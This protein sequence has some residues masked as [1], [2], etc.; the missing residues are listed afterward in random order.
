MSTIPSGR[1]QEIEIVA[2]RLRCKTMFTHPQPKPSATSQSS[3]SGNGT[4]SNGRSG[5]GAAAARGGRRIGTDESP[6]DMA[7]YDVLGLKAN[8]TTDEVKKAYRRLAI[9]VCHADCM[10]A[11]AAVDGS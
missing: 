8:C 4:N 1:Y 11:H 5:M 6:I 2:D 9:K 3:T 10:Q 7:Y